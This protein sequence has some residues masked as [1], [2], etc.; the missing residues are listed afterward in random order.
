[1]KTTTKTTDILATTSR[2]RR[3]KEGYERGGDHIEITFVSGPGVKQRGGTIR[4]TSHVPDAIADPVDEQQKSKGGGIAYRRNQR[5]S[6]EGGI[7]RANAEKAVV[8][9]RLEEATT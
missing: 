1:M 5:G 9:S 7:L 3:E 4:D 2:Q 6:Y 8:V